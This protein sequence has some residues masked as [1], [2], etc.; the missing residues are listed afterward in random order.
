MQVPRAALIGAASDTVGQVLR[1]AG[2]AVVG[3]LQVLPYDDPR[4]V[5]S[6]AAMDELLG[7]HLDAVALDGADNHLVGHLP[8]LLAARLRVLLP[9]A[10]PKDLDVLRLCREEA[11]DADVLVGLTERWEPWAATT[12]AAVPL[13][14][15]PVLQCTVRGWPRGAGPAAELVDLVRHWC[16]DVVTVIAA[17]APLPAAE[18]APGVPVAWAL[19]HET[20]ATTLVSHEDGPPLVRLSFATARWEAGPLGARWVGGAEVPLLPRADGDPYQD[21]TWDAVPLPPAP[22]GTAPGLLCTARALARAPEPDAWTGRWPAPA[23]L[24]DL[25]AVARVLAAL[26]ESARTEAPARVG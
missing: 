1:A 12:T 17:P 19:L 25:Q 3:A 14:G 11:P 21:D 9:T 10:A 5:P 8:D 20:G 13:P 16:G 7:D 26:R 18:L 24:D 6:Y 22:P 2:F 15:E 23:R 4:D